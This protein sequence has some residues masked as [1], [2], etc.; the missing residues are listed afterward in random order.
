[1]REIVDHLVKILMTT[2]EVEDV[3]PLL[4]PPSLNRNK[5]LSHLLLKEVSLPLPHGSF[6]HTSILTPQW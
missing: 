4:Q 3:N 6:S 1:V 2:E 5:L